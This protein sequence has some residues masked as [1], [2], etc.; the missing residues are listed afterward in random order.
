M[1]S[2]RDC[3]AAGKAALAALLGTSSLSLIPAPALAQQPT[4]TALQFDSSTFTGVTGIRGDNMTGNY[5]IPNGGGPTGGLLYRF[6][7]G[8]FEPF[9]VATASGVNFPGATTSTPYGPTFGAPTG[10]LRVVGSY[11]T[12]ASAPFNLSF[13]YDGATAP[14]QQI[15]TLAF[16]NPPG[17]MTKETIA[18][19][20]FGNQVVGNYDTRLAT[21]NA[22]IYDIPSATYTTNNR[23]GATSTTAYG[24]WGN[25]IAGGTTDGGGRRARA[26]LHLQPEHR[27]LHALRRARRR[28]RRHAF[29]G[30]HRRRPRRRIQSGR[31]FRRRQR[32]A[33][34]GGPC[35][36]QRRGDLDRAQ[37]VRRPDLGKLDLPGHGDRHFRRRQQHHQS[38]CRPRPG[39][40]QSDH[41][42]RHAHDKH[43]RQRGNFGRERRRRRQPRH[44]RC[45]GSQQRG[46]RRRPIWRHHQHRIDRRNGRRQRRGPDEWRF[47]L[48]DQYRRPDPPRPAPSPSRPVRRRSAPWSSTAA[49]STVRSRWRPD[50]SRASRTAAGWASARPA[51]ASRTRSAASSPRPRTARWRCASA[52][53]SP[54]SLWSTARRGLPERRWPRSS[55]AHSATTTRCCRRRAATPAPSTRWR[56][57]TCPAS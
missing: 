39:T 27:H 21:G 34:L 36:C 22:F 1:G 8:A 15:T 46:R 10:I 14:G 17:D 30:H 57:R 23:P 12:P 33:R 38:L 43:A 13:L 19:S 53:A 54:T 44:H 47:R 37:G 6:S 28:H 40:L 18:H 11:T 20:T 31:R 25:R 41:E 7:T 48:A 51:P 52:T 42:H 26:R 24:V 9:P 49:S 55:R 16:P 32:G 45:R 2:R 29:R 35:R 5:A 3:V 4:Y 50:P 56:R